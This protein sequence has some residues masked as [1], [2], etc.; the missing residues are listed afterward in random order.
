[1]T[2]RVTSAIADRVRGPKMMTTG[3]FVDDG[4]SVAPAGTS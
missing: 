1:M 2:V 3:T 4:S